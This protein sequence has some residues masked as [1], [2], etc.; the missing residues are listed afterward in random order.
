MRPLHR[1]KYMDLEHHHDLLIIKNIPFSKW[2]RSKINFSFFFECQEV[3]FNSN[4]T[5]CYVSICN[6]MKIKPNSEPVM[7]IYHFAINTNSPITHLIN[8]FTV[9]LLH[10]LSTNEANTI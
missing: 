6:N 10:F 8:V 1:K 2:F 9:F 4:L 3:P 7:R 5:P